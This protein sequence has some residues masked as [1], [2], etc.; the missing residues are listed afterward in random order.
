MWVPIM[1]THSNHQVVLNSAVLVG[2]FAVYSNGSAN[3]I[4]GGLVGGIADK[5]LQF[6]YF[7]LIFREIGEDRWRVISGSHQFAG[8]AVNVSGV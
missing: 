3:T 1:V 6:A 5:M 4:D 7:D 2:G 8:Q